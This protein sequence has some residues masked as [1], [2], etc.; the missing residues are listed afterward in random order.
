MREPLEQRSTR[1]AVLLRLASS[2]KAEVRRIAQRD[3]ESEA[4]VFRRLLRAGLAAER[5]DVE[6]GR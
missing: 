5:R 1:Q 3:D 2:L 4:A 6:G